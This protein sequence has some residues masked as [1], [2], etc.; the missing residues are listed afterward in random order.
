[1]YILL[2]VPCV[3]VPNIL[4]ADNLNDNLNLNVN[5]L[6]VRPLK[7][8]SISF[9]TQNVQSL[10]ISTLCKKTSRKII[11][12]T[13]ER[14]DV[15]FLSDIRLNSNKQTAA[16][17]DITKRFSFRGYN[18]IHNSANNSRGV[19][20]LISNKVP[21]TI[22]NKYCDLD[23][24]IILLDITIRTTRMTIGSVYGPNNNS[25]DFFN[26]IRD[27]C[28]RLN[29]KLIV[30][31]GDWNTTVDSNQV[32]HNIDTINMADIPSRRR[33]NWLRS[34][35]DRLYLT[36]PYRFFYPDRL[37]YTYVPN[38]QASINRSRLDFFQISN[39]L[40]PACK[41]CTISHHLDSMLFD[42]KS[43]RL[44][45]RTS[46]NTFKQTI[47][48][49]ILSDID[50]ESRVRRQ[51]IEHYL[52]HARTGD[53]L[54]LDTKQAL[55]LTIGQIAGKHETIRQNL[56]DIAMGINNDNARATV[57]R[58]RGEI[59]TLFETLPRIDYFESLALT[60]DDKSF[61]ETLL[62]TIKNTALS[63]Q[64]S[65]YKIKAISKD[66]IKKRLSQLKKQYV[67]NQD[68]IFALEGRL[69]RI[70]ETE[71]R[72]EVTLIRNFEKL[73]DK[74]ITPY[75]MAL[76]KQTTTDAVL[77]DIRNDNGTE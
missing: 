66:T 44:T 8:P 28:S 63:A 19:G 29:N 69:S 5:N 46:N 64:Q 72:D 21:Y 12:V 9:L 53:D 15:I 50:L 35:C 32:R 59:V 76:A 67:A 58:A 71:L 75:F 61:F 2:F 7:F 51:V 48:D 30:I 25:A 47:K 23:C 18:F 14:D 22:H 27:T 57:D 65:F 36:D 16:V 37:E 40:I 6:N 1:V 17:L 11:S 56:V 68:E 49:T 55:L 73:N 13:R 31:G 45:F 39:D 33:S 24:N 20:I 4:I 10:N 41:N 38:A 34:L 52:H 60:C 54:T 77:S 3:V 74:K 26:D 70:V 42:H 62:M 43:V